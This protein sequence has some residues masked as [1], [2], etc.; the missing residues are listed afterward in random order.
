MNTITISKPI[1]TNHVD[2][3]F[4]KNLYK[5]QKFAF[6][7]KRLGVFRIPPK[8]R[9]A[10]IADFQSMLMD[11]TRKFALK[12]EIAEI[13]QE[14]LE[15]I[16]H[17]SF[18]YVPRDFFDAGKIKFRNLKEFAQGVLMTGFGALAGYST[19]S[20]IMF[21]SLP[22]IGAVDLR[23]LGG[24]LSTAIRAVVGMGGVV[25]TGMVFGPMMF[26][27]FFQ[28]TSTVFRIPKELYQNAKKAISGQKWANAAREYEKFVFE[29]LQP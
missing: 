5:A 24:F 13:P 6:K 16:A 18:C 23:F 10:R 15:T 7:T 29:H 9:K 4:A 27:G 11:E 22:F 20:Y 17:Y 26:M 28:A 2:A 12:N 3:R 14:K 19:A 21:S 1:V 8:V 25:L